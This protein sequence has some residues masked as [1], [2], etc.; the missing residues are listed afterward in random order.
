VFLI[1]TGLNVAAGLGELDADLSWSLLKL[2]FTDAHILA[3]WTPAFAL[4]VL[5]RII[6]H[7]FHHQLIFPIC[8]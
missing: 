1:Q 8:E 6:T 7:K 3:L 5:L 4:A 2:Y